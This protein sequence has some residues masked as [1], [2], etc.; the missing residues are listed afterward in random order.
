MP[1]RSQFNPPAQ[2]EMISEAFDDASANC[3]GMRLNPPCHSGSYRLGEADYRNGQSED[4]MRLQLHCHS[5]IDLS[6]PGM[7]S[8]LRHPP[9]QDRR[10]GRLGPTPSIA[11]LT[12][13]R[14][15]LTDRSLRPLPACVFAPCH[16]TLAAMRSCLRDRPPCSPRP[17]PWPRCQHPCLRAH[18]FRHAFALTPSARDAPCHATA[19][20]MMRSYLQGAPGLHAFVRSRP[21]SSLHAMSRLQRCAV[22]FAIAPHAVQDRCLGPDASIHAFAMRSCLQGPGRARHDHPDAVPGLRHRL[23]CS[24]RRSRGTGRGPQASQIGHRLRLVDAFCF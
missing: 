17:L 18:A 10:L 12:P 5:D 16:V 21:A 20:R 11:S 8:C 15:P 3:R 1:I 9:S 14:L 6:Q 19:P 13:S 22:A 2:T 7:R 23:R 4:V 24:P